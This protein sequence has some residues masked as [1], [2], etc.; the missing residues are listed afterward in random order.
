MHLFAFTLLDVQIP[1]ACSLEPGAAVAQLGEWRELLGRVDHR[2]RVSPNR[3]ELSLLSD[4]D[5][6]RV[7]HLAQREIACC[8]FFTFTLE[9]RLERLILA[10]EVPNDAVEVL[11]ELVSTAPRN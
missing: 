7:V 4:S 8:P 9:I 6:G 10:I 2:E 5:I 11:D 3:L 1:I